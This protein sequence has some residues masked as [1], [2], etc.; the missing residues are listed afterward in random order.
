M[1]LLLE[2][3]YASECSSMHHWNLVWQKQR[4]AFAKQ[5]QRTSATTLSLILSPAPALLPVAVCWQNDLVTTTFPTRPLECARG[6]RILD[7]ELKIPKLTIFGRSV[8]L[9]TCELVANAVMWIVSGLLFG[10]DPEMRSILNLALLAWV[11]LW[12]CAR[13]SLSS[14]L[15]EYITIDVGLETR[16][17]WDWFG[18]RRSFT[19]RYFIYK[20]LDA[21]HIRYLLLIQ[22]CR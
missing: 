4:K 5:V 9:I 10:R 19:D 6:V 2:F 15:V 22:W 18:L 14:W 7:M 8:L 13:P 11:H 12:F 3:Y 17:V 20:A 21:D 16:S 1:K